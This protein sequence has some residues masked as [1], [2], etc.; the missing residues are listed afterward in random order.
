MNF[1]VSAGREVTFDAAAFFGRG[2][3]T[4]Y[5]LILRYGALYGPGTWY[6]RDGD[7][8]EQVRRRRFPLIGGGGG[9][10]SWLHV[11][12]AADPPTVTWSF[13]FPVSDPNLPASSKKVAVS[14]DGSTVASVVSD[15]VTQNS[16]LY[17][18]EA[19]TGEIRSSRTDALRNRER[20]LRKGTTA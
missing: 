2:G 8:A 4:L 17:V 20:Q 9:L 3:A 18:F 14:Y 15:S 1:G 5:G 11:E 16:T 19:D 7:I 13:P 12:A 6:A 10:I